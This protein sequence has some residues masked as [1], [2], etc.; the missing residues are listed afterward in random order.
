MS[1]ASTKDRARDQPDET[2]TA[3]EFRRDP[4]AVIGR[5]FQHGAV[6]VTGIDPNE[7]VR[8]STQAY[9]IKFE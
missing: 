1:E 5:A 7:R 2:A 4:A 3:A 6:V 8:F 9:D